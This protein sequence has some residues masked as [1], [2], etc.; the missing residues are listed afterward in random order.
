MHLAALLRAPWYWQSSLS[1]SKV[2]LVHGVAP[3]LGLKPAST[4]GGRYDHC[5]ARGQRYASPRR[6]WPVCTRAA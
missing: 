6:A 3:I 1:P 4:P 2:S 5:G